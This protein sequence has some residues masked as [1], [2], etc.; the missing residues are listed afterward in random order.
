MQTVKTDLFLKIA[1]AALLAVLVYVIYD[2][3]HE[4]V[5]AQGD[6][7]PAFT[8]LEYQNLVVEGGQEIEELLRQAQE[9]SRPKSGF[10][11]GMS[12]EIRTPM[13]GVIDMI[14]LVLHTAL[15][16]EEGEHISTVRD[17]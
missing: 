14:Q 8:V 12:R 6:S 13:N 7:A 11:A 1:I 5:V 9:V 15:D 17:S 10:L 3:L 2:G 4:R 16:E